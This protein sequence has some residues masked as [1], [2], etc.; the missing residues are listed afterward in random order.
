MFPRGAPAQRL[1]QFVGHVRANE[2][3]FAIGHLFFDV[4]L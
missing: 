4:S 1:L 2:D 3:S